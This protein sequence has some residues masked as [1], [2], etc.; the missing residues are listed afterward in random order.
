VVEKLKVTIILAWFL[1]PDSQIILNSFFGKRRG[2]CKNAA[3]T[4]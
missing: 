3:T 1:Y 2:K 4:L